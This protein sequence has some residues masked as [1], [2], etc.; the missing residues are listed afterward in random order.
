MR[1]FLGTAPAAQGAVELLTAPRGRAADPPAGGEA[2]AGVAAAGARGAAV[3][4]GEAFGEM[5]LFPE[6]WN[7]LR[8]ET[9]V[10]R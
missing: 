1:Y 7:G 2:G 9:A 5:G 8:A 3:G 6:L 4:R 10:V